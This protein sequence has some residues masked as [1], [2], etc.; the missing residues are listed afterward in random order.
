MSSWSALR[1]LSL[2]EAAAL[3]PEQVVNLSRELVAA[4][5][6]L[7]WF[8]RQL[9]GQKSER[10]IVDDASAQMS[11]GEAINAAQSAPAP[12][13]PGHRVS[14][15]TRLAARKTVESGDEGVQF[16]DE[17][18]VPVEVIELP[19]AE[20]EGLSPQDHEVIG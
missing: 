7:D 10:R 9:F 2:D 17:T 6:Q 11:L 5:K 4:R 3:A 18:R 15:H 13:A 14:A 20:T 19:A 1:A 8:K 12:P 16:F